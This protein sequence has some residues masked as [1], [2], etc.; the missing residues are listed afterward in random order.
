MVERKTEKGRERGG[1][2]TEEAK[3]ESVCERGMD[4]EREGVF[5]TN[6]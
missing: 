4:M 3:R 6:R 2:K 5:E 1:L